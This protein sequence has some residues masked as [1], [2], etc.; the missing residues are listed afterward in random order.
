MPGA[1]G[2]IGCGHI[3]VARMN[4]L[5]VPDKFK[6]SL[7]SSQ[8]C[9][10]IR[11]A[12]LACDPA[13]SIDTL[14]LADGGEGTGALLTEFTHG[15]NIRVMVHDPLFRMIEASYGIS[16]DGKTAFIEMARASGLQLLAT[17]ERNPLHT[18]SLGTGDLIRHALDHQVETIVLGIGGSATNDAG[19]GIGQA[20][21]LKFYTSRQ[22]ELKP[23]GSSLRDVHRIDVNNLH[24]RCHKV[25][26]IVLC[27]VDNPLYGPRGAAE[28]Y[29]P[30][31]GASEETVRLLDAGLKHMASIL[32]QTFQLD[33]DFPGAGAAG[34]V[35]VM[36]KS[37][38]NAKVQSG[39]AFISAFTGLEK[40]IASADV[41]ITGEGKMDNQTLSG[42]VVQG[43]AAI[44]RKHGKKVIAVAGRCDLS[45]GQLEAIGIGEVF[46][47]TDDETS[48]KQA[49]ERAAEILQEKVKKR[50]FPLLRPD[51]K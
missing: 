35:S 48:E 19:L 18:T 23:V 34:G 39:M 9:E 17:H 28:V 30:Q 6:G 20:L 13:F 2:V 26:L 4:I 33:V 38:M 51:K 22:R 15:S 14:P 8:V 24:P 5:I 47:L 32:H 50:L 31:K 10:A 42:K 27:D 21:G 49:M 36:L 44:G 45:R 3:A 11:Q 46:T 1:H 29:A 40:R 12:L 7:T 16:E 25:E 37:I 41:I 43:V